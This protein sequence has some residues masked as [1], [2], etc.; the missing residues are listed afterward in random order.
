MKLTSASILPRGGVLVLAAMAATC[1]PMLLVRVLWPDG[2]SVGTEY[3][4]WPATA[5]GVAGL[6]LLDWRFWSAPLLG[7]LLGDLWITHDFW[8]SL[9]NASGAA[10][11]ALIATWL[12]HRLGNFSG[13]FTQL[14]AVGALLAAAILA[15]FA[16]AIPGVACMVSQGRVPESESASALGVW[17]LANGASM[18]MLT[19]FFV[20]IFN[21]RWNWRVRPGEALGWL[22]AGLFLGAW[23]FNSVFQS[24][25]TNLAFLVFPFR[26]LRG[27]ALRARGDRRRIGRRDGLDLPARS[28]GTH[29]SWTPRAS[30]RPSGSSRHSASCSQRPGWPRPRSSANA[31]PP[32]PAC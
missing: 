29:G 14:K 32:K 21:G 17:W 2:L 4:F 25:A 15:P 10:A 1:F 22:V 8:R 30:R 16:S 18:L 12:L 5:I 3:M 19:P 27:H 13:S 9:V 28:R 23:A 26:H 20:A 7:I 31:A 24:G 11:E 6:L